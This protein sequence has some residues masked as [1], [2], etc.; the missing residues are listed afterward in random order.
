ML[1][2]T[3]TV[4]LWHLYVIAAAFGAFDAFFYPA[5]ASIVPSLLESEQL[6]AGNSLLQSSVQLTGLI[7]PATAGLAIGV[8]GLSAAFGVDAA[9]FLVISASIVGKPHLRLGKSCP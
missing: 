4:H 6:A 3:H 7:G 2:Y 1:V 8:A 9:S 5:Y